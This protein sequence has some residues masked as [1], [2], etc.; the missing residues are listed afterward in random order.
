MSA[1]AQRPFPL[2]PLSV[3]HTINF[4]KIRR[5]LRQ[6][7]RT[8]ASEELPFVR[9][10]S[11]LDKPPPSWLWTFLRC[12]VNCYHILHDTK[13]RVVEA[14]LSWGRVWAGFWRLIAS[15]LYFCISFFCTG[16]Q[17]L[18]PRVWVGVTAVTQMVAIGRRRFRT[19]LAE[20]SP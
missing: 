15:C 2:E 3:G 14:D 6:N 8:S 18:R 13:C 11:A 17:T 7:V 19:D 10:M 20:V 16:G 4:E 5:F 12:N 9:K 1:L